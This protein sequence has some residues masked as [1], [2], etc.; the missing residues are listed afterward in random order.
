[1]TA[2][3]AP[4]DEPTIFSAI[5]TPHRSLSSR[6]FLI[7]MVVVGAISFVAGMAFLLMGA[8]PVFGF[9]GLDVALIYWAFHA[10]YRSG[11]AYEQVTVTPSEIRVRNVGHRGDVQEWSL[12]PLWARLDHETIEEF[13]IHR[14]YVVSRGR[15]MPIAGFLGPGEKESFA[16]ALA[17]AL[18]AAKS[19]PV[20][21]VL[22]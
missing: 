3:N 20:R 12:N 10:N 15:R 6:G 21:T 7:L 16:K 2:G 11:I 8:W 18:A 1:M 5:L 13:G 14:L 4:D 17:A 9:F 22:E 19:G